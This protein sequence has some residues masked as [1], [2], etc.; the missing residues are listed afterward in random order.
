MKYHYT[1]APRIC[2]LCGKEYQ[3]KSHTQKYCSTKCKA[4]VST[5][6]FRD[7]NP[8]YWEQYFKRRREANK[9]NIP[10]FVETMPK[11]RCKSCKRYH[12]GP[13]EFCHICIVRKSNHIAEGCE[14][15]I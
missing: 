12:R 5:K 13:F 9:R 1:G 4:K 8:E 7:R 15:M 10:K 3:P 11:R 14:M 2:E 6:K